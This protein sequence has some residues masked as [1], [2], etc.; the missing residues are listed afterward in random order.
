MACSIKSGMPVFLLRLY[1]ILLEN[2]H[3]LSKRNKRSS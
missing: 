3:S 1:G 2:F